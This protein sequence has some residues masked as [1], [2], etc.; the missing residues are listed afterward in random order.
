MKGE[1]YLMPI[2]EDVVEGLFSTKLG[3]TCSNLF[4]KQK[5]EEI[6][7]WN[8]DL[9]SSQEY[10]LMMRLFKV[11][12]KFKIDIELHQLKVSIYLLIN[13]RK[14]LLNDFRL[15]SIIFQ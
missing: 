12:S 15:Y 6:G 8:V 7:G 9:K 4:K 2:S 1:Q 5:L 3:N 13:K 10:D 11:N 14:I